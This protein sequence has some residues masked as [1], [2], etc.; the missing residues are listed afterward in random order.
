MGIINNAAQEAAIRHETG[1]ALVLA[2]PGSGKTYVITNRLKYLT[3]NLDIDASSVLTITFTKA[4]AAE[5]KSRTFSLMGEKA[6]ALNFGTFHAVFYSILR[7]TFRL[8]SE[9]IITDNIRNTLLR[10]ILRE[11]CI[12]VTDQNA[13]ICGLISAISRRKNIISEDVTDDGNSLIDRDEFNAVY[14]KYSKRMNE[15]R[16]LDFDD[17]LLKC[18]ELFLKRPE[19]LKQ[20]QQRYKWILIDEFQ[21]INPLQYEVVKML[22]LPENNL[23]AVGDDDQSI[24]GF[25]GSRPGIMKEFKNEYYDMA[26]YRLSVNYRSAGP[27]VAAAGT[28]IAD[29]RDRFEKEI[30]AF[31]ISGDIVEI[32]EFTD[33][34]A[35]MDEMLAKFRE[36]GREYN[37]F[38][39]LTRT[40]SAA[41]YIA[42]KLT[43][44]GIPY[45]AREYI[46][47]IYDSFIAQ[48]IIGY[49][50]AADGDMSRGNFYRIMN[51]PQRFISRSAVP[52]ETA[53]FAF[54]KKYYNDNAQEKSRIER[55][56]YDLAQMKKM[57]PFMAVHYLLYGMG[58]LQHLKMYAAGQN[59]DE[60]MLEETA[61]EMKERA[62]E[63]TSFKTWFNAIEEY[64]IKAE[65][66]IRE[67][68]DDA[69]SIMTIHASKGLEFQEVYITDVNEG[70]IPDRKAVMPSEIEE[71]R[72][73]FY[74]AMT[75]AEK[76]LHLFSI[77]N[78]YGKKMQPSRFIAKIAAD[79]SGSSDES[80]S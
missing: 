52:E 35:E 2:G 68:P 28:V 10:D 23:F 60:K 48:D 21:D 24:Y 3:E 53:D 77:K 44:A 41:G 15:L 74:V 13:L 12:K 37:D 39:V 36:N 33:R 14:E 40:N 63:Y 75:R 42:E 19:I 26:L 72:R 80:E 64:R 58:Y 45:R 56:E 43:G 78:N 76:K 50:I 7:R 62:R 46:A 5:M 6:S 55:F 34:E 9:N 65:N 16:L 61:L 54:M 79:Y 66:E 22:A 17:M 71:E 31:D 67:E 1:P 59:I 47:N 57:K 38:A 8:T 29:N 32:K 27:I 70:I 30:T 18:R 69:V 51:R 49:C 73:L 25:R 20:W 11:L 4:A